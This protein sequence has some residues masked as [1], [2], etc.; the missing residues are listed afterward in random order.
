ME[1]IYGVPFINVRP[2]WLHNIETGVSLELDCYNEDL[3]LAVEYNG[4]QHY[5]WPNFTNQSY[6]Q[7][8]NQV[9]RDDLKKRLCEKYG[10]YLINVP[11][12][13]AHSK[14]P[15]FLV[16]HLPEVVQKRIDQEHLLNELK[17]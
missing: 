4:I 17:L 12:V 3:K 2:K 11:Y 6:Q 15:Q 10:I 9:R 14:I 7:F 8:I 16:S 13:I 1:K 5:K